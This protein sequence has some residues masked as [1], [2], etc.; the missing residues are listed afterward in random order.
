MTQRRALTSLVGL[1]LISL[2]AACSSISAGWVTGKKYEP[3]Y[4]YFTTYCAGYNSQGMC[5]AWYQQWHVSPEKWRLD[6]RDNDGK[7]GWV[8]VTPETYD[9]YQIGDWVDF[10]DN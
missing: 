6:I 8:Y 4:T 1:L 10:S 5:T 9:A 3:S 7:D 2:L